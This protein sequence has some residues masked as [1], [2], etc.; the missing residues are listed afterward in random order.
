M[1]LE[2]NPGDCPSGGW[3][4]CKQL[5]LNETL[6]MRAYNF[7]HGLDN[8]LTNGRLSNQKIHF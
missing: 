4:G 7:Q 1:A 8:K 5:E 6:D 2:I 3:V